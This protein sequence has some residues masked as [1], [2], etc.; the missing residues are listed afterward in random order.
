MRFL[1]KDHLPIHAMALWWVLWLTVAVSKVNVFVAPSW[2]VASQFV[3]F[4]L[5]FVLG[6]VIAVQLG[7][8]AMA[9]SPANDSAKSRSTFK[10]HYY[11]YAANWICLAIL[12]ISLQLS[13]ALSEGFIEYFFKLRREESTGD[14]VTGSRLLDVATKV[15]VWPTAY[16]LTIIVLA[17]RIEQRRGM[18]ALSI[19]NILLFSYLWQVNYSLIY[20]FWIFVFYVLVGAARDL[21]VDRKA[22]AF[23]GALMVLLVAVAA[24]RFGGDIFGGLQRYVFG[25][26]TAGFSFYDHHFHNPS[27]LL[28]QH[29]LG[30]SSLGFLE[31][32]LEIISRRI[33]LGFVAASSENATFNNEDIDIGA[34]EVIP[35]NAFGTF[36]F[37]FYRDFHVAGIVAGGLL[38]GGLATHLLA[39]G[40]QSWPCTSAFYV[41]ATSWMVGMM[42]NPIEQAHFWFSILLI[43]MLSVLN[44]GIR[45]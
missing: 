37:G 19:L 44:R 3:A 43:G 5:F 20:L 17:V 15:L 26:H 6:H 23:V 18:L 32:L 22:L 34:F 45:L 8:S 7:G 25:Y 14:S 12:L 33:D 9:R 35:G 38:Y 29:S 41:L 27:S 4:T 2:D 42:V 13:G 21:P 28:H 39:K 36:L 11:L 31:Q 16:T 10:I 30:R 1:H 40:R 24:N